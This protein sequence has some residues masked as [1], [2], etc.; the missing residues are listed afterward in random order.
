MKDVDKIP[1][2]E[3]QIDPDVC[4]IQKLYSDRRHLLRL[5][6][7]LIDDFV[8]DGYTMVPEMYNESIKL[9]TG[10]SYEELEDL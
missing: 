2:F 10:K 7:R 1:G 9:I 5:A 8:N 4:S 6:L 3:K